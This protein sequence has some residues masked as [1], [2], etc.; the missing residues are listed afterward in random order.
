MQPVTRWLCRPCWFAAPF[1]VRLVAGKKK[2]GVQPRR[3]VLQVCP[4]AP[5]ATDLPGSADV[6]WLV[7]LATDVADRT[8]G[9]IYSF[10]ESRPRAPF[11]DR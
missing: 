2:M 7:P 1:N 6:C 8:A 9:V 11:V 3:Q 10:F 4:F 5:I